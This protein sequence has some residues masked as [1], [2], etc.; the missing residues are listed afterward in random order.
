VL[1]PAKLIVADLSDQ[2]ALSDIFK[3][4]DPEAVLHFSALTNVAESLVNPQKYY[5][6]NVTYGLNLLSVIEASGCKRVIFSSTAAVYGD[7]REVPITEESPIKPISPYGTSKA[8]FEQIL[9]DFD[10][11][12]GIK[13]VT[14]R[15]FNAAGADAGGRLGGNLSKKGDLISVLIKTA[16]GSAEG[17]RNKFTINGTDYDT[18]DGTCIRDMVHVSDLADAHVRALDYL[19]D[20]GD[21]DIFNLGSD[22]GCSVREAAAITKAVT[23]VDFEIESGPRRAGDIAVSIASSGKARRIMGW[24]KQHS[25][26]EEIIRTTWIWAKKTSN[27]GFE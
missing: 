12:Y 6:N 15:Y 9:R 5:L 23:G 26:I 24:E 25:S 1:T 3:R 13:S 27:K 20:G 4:H 11:A 22:T 8:F 19:K 7:A 10:H 17:G 18:R 2:G 16:M 21:S 14:L